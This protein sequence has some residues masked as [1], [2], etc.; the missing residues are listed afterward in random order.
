M[1]SDAE[2]IPPFS[3]LHTSNADD[4]FYELVGPL[5]SRREIVKELGNPVWDDDGK[6]WTVAIAGDDVLGIC[7]AHKKSICSFYVK[8]GN[9]GMTIGYAL[10]YECLKNNPDVTNAVATESSCDLFV[11]AGFT[12]TGE[13]GRYKLMTRE[14]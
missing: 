14:A 1:M 12:Q 2:K 5:L 3:F 4:G 8:P 13:R 6:Q 9:R 11:A 7:A 10:L